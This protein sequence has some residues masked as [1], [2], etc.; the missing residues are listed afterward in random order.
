[1]GERM[2][3]AVYLYGGI[4]RSYEKEGSFNLCRNVGEF[5]ENDGR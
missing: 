5:L 2:N 3:S 1:M 4:L